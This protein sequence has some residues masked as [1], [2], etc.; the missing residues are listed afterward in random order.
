MN[1]C[2]EEEGLKINVLIKIIFI[3]T[4]YYNYYVNSENYV[5]YVVEKSAKS[6]YF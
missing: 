2:V 5:L 3:N 6:V 4:V 1:L